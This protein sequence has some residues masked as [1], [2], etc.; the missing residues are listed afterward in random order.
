[1]LNRFQIKYFIFQCYNWGAKDLLYFC[2][3]PGQS[4][5]RLQKM[6]SVRRARTFCMQLT[7][8]LESRD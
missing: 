3:E 4:I 1:M 5:V 6:C 7:A 2:H 8:R